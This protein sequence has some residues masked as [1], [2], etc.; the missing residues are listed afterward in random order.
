MANL[1]PWKLLS[2]IKVKTN[3]GQQGF[4]P[5]Q[6]FTGVTEAVKCKS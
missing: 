2:I 3:S 4:D 1:F 5:Q 6:V